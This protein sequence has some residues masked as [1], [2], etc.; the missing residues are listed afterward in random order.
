MNRFLAAQFR[1]P[2]GWFG[3][4]IMGPFMNRINRKITDRTLELLDVLP[5]HRVLEIGFGG[6]V[7]LAQLVKRLTSGKAAGADISEEMIRDA[8][9]KFEREIARGKV[10]IVRGDACHLPFP[11]SSFDRAFTVNTIY[12]WSDTEQGFLE[13]RRVLKKG[14]IAALGLRSKEKMQVRALTQ[15]NFRLFSPEE[16]VTGMRRAGFREIRVDHR[17][18]DRVYDQVV[19]TGINQA[20]D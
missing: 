16:V 15:H 18:R 20:A 2:H 8:E 19:V 1:K 4:M 14:G 11:D 5:E 17:D 6:G 7:A 3:S 9:A 12:F 10:E 13:I